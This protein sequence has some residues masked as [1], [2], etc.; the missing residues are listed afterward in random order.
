VQQA[1]ARFTHDDRGT[2]NTQYSMDY[3]GRNVGLCRILL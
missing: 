3:V 2:W 1:V